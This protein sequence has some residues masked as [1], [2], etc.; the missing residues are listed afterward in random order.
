MQ[1]VKFTSTR[2]IGA[3]GWGD[4][5]ALGR[6]KR[7]CAGFRNDAPNDYFESSGFISRSQMISSAGTSGYLD[8]NSL[9]GVEVFALD[10][11]LSA[12]PGVPVRH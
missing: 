3:T 5:S 7:Q 8:R 2:R 11:R 1:P 6:V 10:M 4:R 12:L 9:S